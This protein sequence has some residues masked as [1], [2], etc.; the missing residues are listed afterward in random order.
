MPR[1][2]FRSW[3]AWNNS[4]N[5]SMGIVVLCLEKLS[6]IKVKLCVIPL[7]VFSLIFIHL[8]NSYYDPV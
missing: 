8:K 4:R 1:N 7:S 5:S 3:R 2:E 6:E